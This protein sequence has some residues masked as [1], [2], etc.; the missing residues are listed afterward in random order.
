[1]PGI[2]PRR[3]NS[4]RRNAPMS[5][6]PD[7]ILCKRIMYIPEPNAIHVCDPPL[8]LNP[9]EVIYH[10]QPALR[11]RIFIDVLEV[12]DWHEPSESSACFDSVSGADRV[13]GSRASG[14]LHP[15]P[16]RIHLAAPEDDATQDQVEP[17]GESAGAAGFMVGNVMFRGRQCPARRRHH[18]PTISRA[19]GSHQRSSRKSHPQKGRLGPLCIL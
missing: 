18:P 15:W 17:P 10:C 16:K 4:F 2:C 8:F 14:F 5:I 11:Y 19:A 12:E 6:H 3:D 1:M 13:L 9:K 7:L